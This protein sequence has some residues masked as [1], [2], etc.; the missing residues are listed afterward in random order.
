VA[1]VV[2][3]NTSVVH[4]YIYELRYD[5]G[6]AYW[7]RCGRVINEIIAAHEKWNFENMG[8]GACHL[9]SSE[10]NLD[11]NYGW[12]KLDLSQTQDREVLTLLPA[13]EFG[14]LAES[15]TEVVVRTLQ[16]GDFTRIGFRSHYLFPTGSVDEAHGLLK[17]LKLFRMDPGT[18]SEIGVTSEVSYRTVVQRPEHKLRIAVAPFEQQVNLPPGV[19]QAARAKARDHW[20]D[21]KDVIKAKL[22]AQHMI[23]HLPQYGLL[24]DLDASLEEPPYPD[25]ISV[26]DF[27]TRA[28]RDFR[29][30][31]PKIL[32]ALD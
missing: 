15:L 12:A 10:Q 23:K 13:G 27:V 17:R 30:L 14:A 28:E 1:A 24:L 19:I 4:R 8:S 29:D 3:L 2:G 11:F 25:S 16:L 9:R 22:K 26:S 5:F 6:H 7:D 31:T 21:Q 20:K 18:E 32:K